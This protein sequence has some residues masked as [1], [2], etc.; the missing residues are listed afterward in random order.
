MLKN[1]FN[2]KALYV[3]RISDLKIKTLKWCLTTL[4]DKYPINCAILLT[5]ESPITTETRLKGLNEVLLVAQ[6]VIYCN[7]LD[8]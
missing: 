5:C 1:Y 7:A 6:E 3:A 4:R 8:L 2:S